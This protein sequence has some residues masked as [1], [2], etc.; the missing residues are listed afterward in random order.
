[1]KSIFSGLSIVTGILLIGTGLYLVTLYSKA[2]NKGEFDTEEAPNNIPPLQNYLLKL[3]SSE[4]QLKDMVETQQV[5]VNKKDELNKCI[6]NNMN[7]G[8]LFLNPSGRIEIFNSVAQSLFSQSYV[9]A[10]NNVPEKVLIALP[11]VCQLVTKNSGQPASYE[12]EEGDRVF[13]LRMNPIDNI[14]Q[15]VIIRDITEDRK[16]EEIARRNG[17]FIML[18]EM[19][20]F[21]A[22][23]VKNALGVMLGYTKTMKSEQEKAGKISKEILF[24][25]SM[26]EGFL[27][28]SK[29]VTVNTEQDLDLAEALKE[30]ADEKGLA[31]T[32]TG[33][34]TLK[35]DPTL[36]HSIFSNLVLN[37]A[38]AGADTLEVRL[39]QEKDTEIF[40]EDNGAGMPE[41]IR[42]KIWY[43][44]F[45]TKDKGTGMGLASIRKIVNSLAGEISLESSSEK[46]TV[47]KLVFYPEQEAK[48]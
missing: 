3:R 24:L 38:Q 9:N 1:L 33:A 4:S 42:E 40:L 26:M 22:H 46:G 5:S 21:L 18:G 28:F 23:E 14:G 43:P 11:T 15:L 37:S 8:I 7:A 47:F 30:I 17:N 34:A 48:D 39:S 2:K 10:L 35:K 6:V 41:D 27:N 36:M 19:T 31:V 29:P 12:V 32:I 45:T 44:F 20:A 16:K 25:T 13:S